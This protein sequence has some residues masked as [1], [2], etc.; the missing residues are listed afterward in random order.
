MQLTFFPRS[1]DRDVIVAQWYN[2]RLKTR[3]TRPRTLPWASSGHDVRKW[4]KGGCSLLP[5]VCAVLIQLLWM[6]LSSL[7][8]SLRT[9]ALSPES[10]LQI[11]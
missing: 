10:L 3:V 6:I 7:D 4:T 5:F 9:V 2:L 8:A 11:S 1:F